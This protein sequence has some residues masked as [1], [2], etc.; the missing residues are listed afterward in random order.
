MD[1]QQFPRSVAPIGETCTTAS[2]A[3]K[4]HVA[5]AIADASDPSVIPLPAR[6][7]LPFSRSAE[8]IVL[9]ARRLPMGALLGLV[10]VGIIRV[11]QAGRPPQSPN[12]EVAVSSLRGHFGGLVARAGA[13]PAGSGRFSLGETHALICAWRQLVIQA[14]IP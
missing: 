14:V 7:R 4:D 3:T 5:A 9:D 12:G 10:V 11:L 2:L 1:Q 8:W 13:V 6:V